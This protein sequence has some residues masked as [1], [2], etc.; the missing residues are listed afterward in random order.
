MT[1]SGLV[2]RGIVELVHVCGA[3]RK[4]VFPRQQP[5]QSLGDRAHR[6]VDIEA[7]DPADREAII[8][9]QHGGQNAQPAAHQP[10]RFEPGVSVAGQHV[11]G[12]LLGGHLLVVEGV[13]ERC[14]GVLCDGAG[15]CCHQVGACEAGNA[16]HQVE[17]VVLVELCASHLFRTS[18]SAGCS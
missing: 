10:N 13:V 1:M 2:R 11:A 3:G 9:E 5:V 17:Y 18:V 7:D 16:A 12:P 15:Q 8:V 14:I 6:R 4:T